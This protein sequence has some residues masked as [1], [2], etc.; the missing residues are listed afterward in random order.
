MQNGLASTATSGPRTIFIGIDASSIPVQMRTRGRLENSRCAGV[1]GSSSSWVP[2]MTRASGRWPSALRAS[3]SSGVEDLG[4]GQELLEELA[5]AR[6]AIADPDQSGH[7]THCEQDRCPS[8]D[9]HRVRRT[10]VPATRL[11][12]TT[13]TT[14]TAGSATDSRRAGRRWRG[15]AAGAARARRRRAAGRHPA[16]GREPHHRDRRP[17]HL[18]PA[19]GRQAVRRRPL[20]RGRQARPEPV[21]RRGGGRRGGGRSAS[22]ADP[23]VG[24]LA[25]RRSAAFGIARAVRRPARPAGRADHD[26]C[27][28]RRGRRGRGLRDAL[29]AGARMPASATRRP[30]AEMPAWGRRRFIGTSIAVIGVAAA[31]GVRRADA[32][33]TRAGSG[34]IAQAGTLPA[35]GGDR[36]AAAGRADRWR[37]RASARS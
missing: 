8:Q 35:A 6:L 36:T 12:S 23:T 1:R 7:V 28:G 13:M 10:M 15:L 21:H 16:R 19:A 24:S 33:R 11:V 4:L 14:R 27:R 26:A 9:R 2:S 37:S 18:A 22:G 32:A 20:R 25:D 29:A 31:S 5:H 34:A 30:E 17:R 3:S